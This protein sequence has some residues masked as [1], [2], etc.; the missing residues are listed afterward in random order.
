MFDNWSRWFLAGARFQAKGE[1]TAARAEIDELKE[2]KSVLGKA[3]ED[4]AKEIRLQLVQ[5][6]VGVRG[7]HVARL[8]AAPRSG[9][10]ICFTNSLSAIALNHRRALPPRTTYAVITGSSP[11]APTSRYSCTM[12]PG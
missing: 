5:V 6:L 9:C 8:Q 1:L 7:S 4:K 10:Y 12:L 2:D 3:L 11:W